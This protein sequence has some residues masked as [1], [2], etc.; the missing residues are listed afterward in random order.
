MKPLIGV[1]LAGGEFGGNKLPGRLGKDYLYPSVEQIDWYAAM[2]MR[3][4]RV[5]FLSA[6]L[7]RE[8]GAYGPDVDAVMAAVRRAARHGIVVVLDLHEYAK[9]PDGTPLTASAKDLS[10]FENTWRQIAEIYRG[11]GNVWLGLMNEPNK[12][13][14]AEWVKLAVAGLAG[15]RE[16]AP[17]IPVAIMGTYWGTAGGFVDQ[18]ADAFEEIVDPNVIVEVHEYFDG[19]G[20]KPL[21]GHRAIAGSA[22]S[23]FAEVTDWAR[24]TGR[25]LYLG[26]FGFTADQGDM[27][28]GRACLSYLAANADVWVGAT[29]WAG[30]WF[31]AEG[32]RQPPYPFSV[33]PRDYDNLR[34]APQ[35]ELLREF[36]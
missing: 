27:A 9:W 26:E 30:G 18:N 35:L 25:R 32:R 14:P 31:W 5:P 10:W 22:D 11:C 23:S 3:I 36:A 29:F 15:I 28:E 24:S 4:L 7:I 34:A 20:G 13:K 2:R 33:E 17:T 12:Q 1:N 19:K 8:N 6:R 16:A 21:D